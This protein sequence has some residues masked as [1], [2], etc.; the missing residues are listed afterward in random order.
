ME[1]KLAKADWP[2]PGSPNCSICGELVDGKFYWDQNEIAHKDCVDNDVQPGNNR[3]D[4]FTWAI[5]SDIS[6]S[7]TS[8]DKSLM[9]LLN[10]ETERNKMLRDAYAKEKVQ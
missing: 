6:H 5:L 4:N 2:R 1:W 3:D 9:A 10:T 7:L 8:I